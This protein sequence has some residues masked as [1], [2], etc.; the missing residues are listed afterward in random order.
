MLLSVVFLVSCTVAFAQQV[1]VD[2]TV[3]D[4]SGE[5]IIGATVIE[6]GTKNAAVTDFDGKFRLKVSGGKKLSISYMGYKTVSVDPGKSL[7]VVMTEDS[8]LID[9]LVVT[10]YTTQRKADLTGAVSV[11]SMD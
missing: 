11:V 2:G 10:G 8:K 6:E 9:E 3:R 5:P 1:D 7:N 4:E